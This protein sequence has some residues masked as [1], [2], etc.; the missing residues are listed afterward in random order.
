L[1]TLLWAHLTFGQSLKFIS[2]IDQDLSIKKVIVVPLSDNTKGIY[3]NPLTKTLEKTLAEDK[4]WDLVSSPTN[5]SFTPEDFEERPETV[6]SVLKNSQADALVSGRI[7]KGP[8]GMS[9]K[10]TLYSGKE[11]LPSSSETL[12]DYQ[13]FE[14]KDL[15]SQIIPLAQKMKAKL[16]YSG[17]VLSRKGQLV[18]LNLGSNRGV[19]EGARL[20]ALQIIK[21]NR[22]PKYKFIVSAET[23]VLGKVTI[24]KSDEFVSFGTVTT[25]REPNLIGAN[26]K[27]LVDKF[28]EYPSSNVILDGKIQTEL[29]E[30]PDSK[31]AFGD[32]PN[33]WVPETQPTFGKLGIMLGLGGYS[34]NTNLSTGSASSTNPLA[35]SIHLNGEMWFDPHWF[36]GLKISNYVFGI[37][38][39]L[40]GS[41]P[42]TLNYQ[43]NT[44]TL[45]GGYNFLVAEDFF[46][47]KIQ[48]SMGYSTI[49][50]MID[51]ST[52]VAHTSTK[53]SGLLIGVAGS[54][55][56]N[57]LGKSRPFFI[58]GRLNLFNLLFSPSLSESPVSSGSS[59]NQITS[60]AAFLEYRMGERMNFKS[61]LM[62]DV[63]S[64][65]FGGGGNRAPS[66]SSMSQSI[67]TLAAGVEYLY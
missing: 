36:G 9:I 62:F 6:R 26:T 17:T 38:N 2:E 56:V 13:G 22:H 18:T 10:L 65:S 16:P 66:A 11:G 28:V 60:F 31:T 4:Q 32:N 12:Q 51:N 34:I 5:I 41:G 63:L 45:L 33:E 25:E 21:I 20:T 30:R 59:Q 64:S 23:T 67:T 44:M 54:I 35:P 37:N 58:G 24:N 1:L 49:T 29:N 52:P 14:V 8:S 27:F 46:G 50:G 19:K 39:G 57:M 47:P 55:P 15:N 48:L 42:A 40:P 53:Y 3:A 43:S 7:S 61:E